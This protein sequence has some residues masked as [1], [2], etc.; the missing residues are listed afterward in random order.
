[1]LIALLYKSNEHSSSMLSALRANLKN[2]GAAAPAARLPLPPA[3]KFPLA[4]CFFPPRPLG[5]CPTQVETLPWRIVLTCAL[6]NA[7]GPSPTKKITLTGTRPAAARTCCPL[8][9]SGRPAPGST[10]GTR[11]ST[12]GRFRRVP[13]AWPRPGPRS[14]TGRTRSTRARSSCRRHN[15]RSCRRPWGPRPR[16]TPASAAGPT[17]P[18]T[19]IPCKR[20]RSARRPFFRRA[21]CRRAGSGRSRRVG[22]RR[23]RRGRGRRGRRRRRRAAPAG[24]GPL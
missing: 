1:M 8:R 13:E 15:R 18:G 4:R 22:P 16:Q 23:A 24:R 20:G 7:F 10:G 5:R 9:A 2:G 12:A 19:T 14:R 11:S 17:W 6:S 3:K 21:S